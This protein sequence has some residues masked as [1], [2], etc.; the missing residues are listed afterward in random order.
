[1]AYTAL[2]RKFRPETFADVRGQD[3]IV[4][5][6]KN[7]IK[8]GRIG[9]AYLFCG[10]RGTGKTTVAR[11]MARAVN[12]ENIEDG[13]PCCRCSMCESIKK[14]TSMN[15]IEIDAASNNGVDNIREIVEEVKY[16]PAEG[17]YKVYIIDEVHMLSTGAFNALLKT[18]EEPPPYVIF[19]LATTEVHKIPITI[20]SR[21]QRYDFKRIS[22][23]VIT[24]M[25]RELTN[26]EQAKADEKALRYIARRAEGAM[27]DALSL[28]D[29]CVSYYLGMELTYDNVLEVLGT[30]DIE[31]FAKLLRYLRKGSVNSCIGLIDEIITSGRDLQQFIED[32]TWY[33]RNLLI[34]KTADD[35]EDILELSL[36][37]I[38]LIK[39]EAISCDIDMIMRCIRIFSELSNQIK[40]V[41]QKRLYIEIALIKMCRPEMETDYES[42]T[43]RIRILEDKLSKDVIS[44]LKKE[45]TAK[46]FDET[47]EELPQT[48]KEVQR[49]VALTEDMQAVAKNWSHIIKKL[50]T[51]IKT[52]LISAKPIPGEGNNLILMFNNEVDKSYIDQEQN[53]KDI[54]EAVAS[55]TGKTIKVSTKMIKAGSENIDDFFDLSK[56]FKNI[57]IQYIDE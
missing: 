24:G 14:Q 45:Q 26:K 29:Q 15:V 4:K 53:I 46:V 50:S 42:L 8:A 21:C 9:H 32:F 48:K 34:A 27:R 35:I 39:Q 31:I 57:P 25:L 12:C 20:M 51:L 56:I 36:E 5:T 52:I 6:L 7:Q 43:E 49:S 11:I 19:I 47:E 30:V 10:T 54:E 28:L 2:Y 1:M 37:Q 22:E 16:S 13:S 3:H 38:K 23:E 44:T 18:L 55:Q 41:S 33:M 40:F 17:R